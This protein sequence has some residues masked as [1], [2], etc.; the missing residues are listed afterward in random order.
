LEVQKKILLAKKEGVTPYL[1]IT[2]SEQNIQGLPALLE[3]I[4][5]HK[6]PFSIN[7]YKGILRLDEEQ[8]ISK[9]LEA[10]KV[11][12][13]NLPNHSLLNSLL[14]MTNFVKPHL[15]GC[16]VGQNYLIFDTEGEISQ[17][18]MTMKTPISSI[19]SSNILQ[20]IKAL[21]NPL[22]NRTVDEHEE[23]KTCQWRYW[24]GGGCAVAN[25]LHQTKSPYCEVY[26]R[27][28]PEVLRLEGLRLLKNFKHSN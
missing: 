1:S 8:L 4:L 11:I 20:K 14:D 21:N 15:R 10:F 3:W 17:C 22:K 5:E 24:C 23:C 16:S 18:P 2:V 27:L 12:E 26:K 28:F 6:L 19:K 13:L 9:M 25:Q 7:F